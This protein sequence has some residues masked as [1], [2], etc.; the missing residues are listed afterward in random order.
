MEI[1]PTDSEIAGLQNSKKSSFS[2][3]PAHAFHLF[4]AAFFVY[5]FFL[6]FNPIS[7]PDFWFHLKTG[8]W[9]T[10]TKSL[11]G[12][13]DPF[14]YT[15]PKTLVGD[16]LKGLRS[17]WLGQALIY[18]VYDAFGFKGFA[19]FRS[20]ILVIPFAFIYLI[21][22]RRTKR[23]FGPFVV[24]AFPPIILAIYFYNQYE[25]PQV[26]SFICFFVL[27]F[28]LHKARKAKGVLPIALICALMILWA[29]M[30]AGYV[31]GVAMISVFVMGEAVALV[32]NKSRYIVEPVLR[33]IVFF[34]GCLG[35]ILLSGLNPAG[36]Q[37][38]GLIYVVLGK[39]I[40][41]GGG[42]AT[43]GG[44]VMG[45]ILEYK[46][47]L[48]FA[49]TLYQSWPWYIFVYYL[50]AWVAIIGKYLLRRQVNPSELL[51]AI[52]ITGFGLYYSRGTVFTL[53]YLSL[54]AGGGFVYFKTSLRYFISISIGLLLTVFI[55]HTYTTASWNLNPK[56]PNQWIQ[57]EYPERAVRF[58]K[59]QKIKGSMFNYME[60]GGYLM[61]RMYP[62]YP[63]FMD[64][65]IIVASRLNLYSDIILAKPG[66][67]KLL[68][69]YG[70]DFLLIP[71]INRISGSL[72]PMIF[73]ISMQG[74]DAVWRVVY[75]WDN[76][77]VYVRDSVKNESVLDC[78]QIKPRRMN[79]QI[80]QSA[81]LM[82]L[83]APGHPN[84]LMT[85]SLALYWDGRYSEAMG[86]LRGLPESN[87]QRQL[88]ENMR[89]GNLAPS[90]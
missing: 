8:E 12:P 9:I 14:S 54:A 68:D 89:R 83:K 73:H 33:P 34:S 30:H 41:Q 71:V 65:R 76:V 90:P 31:I 69:N 52:L 32:L 81:Q 42:V 66:W 67:E 45:E 15:T 24:S 43:E 17:Q 62:E 13:E 40:S 57:G 84:L 27:I 49:Q 74:E 29:N 56:V 16:P 63:V 10:Q 48:Y 61:W 19:A 18:S 59:E 72:N 1:L 37:F 60:W 46:P 22:Y 21:L 38:L 35:A 28:L 77:A 23:F 87:L 5:V 79:E 53:I 3:R 64:G 6:S 88:I 82:L 78:C 20:L 50:V 7:D 11:P 70:V 44:T 26:F 25:R 4:A 58:I 47:I 80:L 36:F 51:G 2:L 85:M 55:A 86:I 75:L 39:V